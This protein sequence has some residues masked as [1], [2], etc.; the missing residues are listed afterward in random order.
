MTNTRAT[1][2]PKDPLFWLTLGTFGSHRALTTVICARMLMV[3]RRRIFSRDP[4]YYPQPDTF[5]PERFLKDGKINPDVR[6]PR[7][8]AFGYGRRCV[9]TSGDLHSHR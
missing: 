4:R 9:P 6:D 5:M 2:Y 8:F 7:V 3:R 1:S